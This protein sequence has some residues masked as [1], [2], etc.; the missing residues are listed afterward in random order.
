MSEFLHNMS[1]QALTIDNDSVEIK[2]DEI[3]ELNKDLKSLIR[4]DDRTNIEIID[5]KEQQFD[6]I[7]DKNQIIEEEV[8][9]NIINDVKVIY[10]DDNQHLSFPNTLFEISKE[11]YEN[12][13]IDQKTFDAFNERDAEISQELITTAR[14]DLIKSVTDEAGEIPTEVLNNI[15]S[16]YEL[17]HES[18]PQ[19]D[20]RDHIQ[21]TI[22]KNNEQYLEKVRKSPSKNPLA[23][24]TSSPIRLT[25]LIRDKEDCKKPYDKE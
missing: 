6:E 22:K 12:N 3:I 1:L 21:S 24:K 17:Q 19:K 15:A 13:K 20:V 16:I 14:N 9:N 2:F 5:F 11:T 18:L 4:D 10:P 8:V 23:I 7:K 25:D